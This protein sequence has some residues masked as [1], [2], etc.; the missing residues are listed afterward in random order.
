M[1]QLLIIEGPDG[2]GKTTLARQVQEATPGARRL[3]YGPPPSYAKSWRDAWGIDLV[4]AR[5]VGH[6]HVISDRG[7]M[8]HAVWHRLM[9]E[10]NE[11]LLVDA[12]NLGDM[13]AEVEAHWHL[14]VVILA[15]SRRG[16]REELASR[17]EDASVP[18][19][20]VAL[21]YSLHRTLVDLGVDAQ[22]WE[23]GAALARDPRGWW[24]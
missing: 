21:Y 11:S 7:L 15:R 9:P 12:I 14:R 3:S 18:L 17:F 10:A 4:E 19:R 22:I 23:S 6:E 20:S 5:V 16:M 24:E 13:L 8:G 2:V 1:G